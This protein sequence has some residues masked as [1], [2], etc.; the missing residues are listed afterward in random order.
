MPRKAKTSAG[1]LPKTK[2]RIPMPQCKA[3]LGSILKLNLGS[4]ARPL[5]G[6]EN[7]DRKTGQEVYPL[8][9][10]DEC[11]D[12]IRASHVLEH[13]SHHQTMDVLTDW[14]RVLKPG[15]VL[16]VAVPDLDII[17][18][19]VVQGD[20]INA[21][22]YLMGGHHD[23]DDHHGAALDRRR[24]SAM[25]FDLGLEQV[26]FWP[27]DQKDCSADC[28][29]LNLQ[30]SKPSAPKGTLDFVGVRACLAAPRYGP[31]E[32]HRRIYDSLRE[33]NFQVRM[34][35]GCFWHQ[36]LSE[37]IEKEIADPETR[38]IM[39]MDYD[40]VFM[41]EDIAEMYRIMETHPHIDA[42]VPLQAHR[43]APHPLFTMLDTNGQRKSEC[44]PS[45]FETL[46]APIYTGHFG[47]T[48][49]RADK[50]REFPRPWMVGVPNAEGRWGDGRVDP[51]IYFWKKW[52]ELGNTVHLANRVGIGH[53][54]DM[55]YWV[56][57]D[58]GRITQ[59][60]TNYMT[61]GKPMEAK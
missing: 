35:T 57:R 9:Y 55:V 41:P 16:K 7:L 47:L 14:V 20:P 46:T 49:L 23:S 44:H 25:F 28:T 8:A 30:A 37:A 2:H 26:R 38:Y 50:L 10:P 56:D 1:V 24:L 12:E 15:G 3:P 45:V 32:H 53:I 19:M 21:Q 54:E 27:S 13:F 17:C 39:T 6:Y 58:L 48:F 59:T 11:A 34:V 4:G 29:S 51:D 33:F 61:T 36:H 43:G 40:S 52:N 60:M 31:S 5:K 42:L 22:A 18:R